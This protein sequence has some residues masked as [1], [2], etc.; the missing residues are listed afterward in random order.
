MVAQA[1]GTLLQVGQEV[2]GRRGVTS[3]LVLLTHN[4]TAKPRNETLV[5]GPVRAPLLMH[6][7]RTRPD[8]H[9]KALPRA[10]EEHLQGTEES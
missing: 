8:R 5:R 6:W 1:A 10:T 4:L 2:V 9:S 7:V 3:W